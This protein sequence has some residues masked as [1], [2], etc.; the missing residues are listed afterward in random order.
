MSWIA[1]ILRSIGRPKMHAFG[2]GA[3]TV[4]AFDAAKQGAWLWFAWFAIV[5]VITGVGAILEE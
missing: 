4:C 5:T 2:C 1:A 3:V